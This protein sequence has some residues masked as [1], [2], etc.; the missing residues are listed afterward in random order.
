VSTALANPSLS[1]E[2]LAEHS[3]QLPFEP[4]GSTLEDVILGAW[5]DLALHRRA[6]CPVCG[7]ELVP[8]GCES[9]GAE[10]S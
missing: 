4:A 6:E 3:A 8:A 7:S 10:L 9:C 5:E 2:S 1:N